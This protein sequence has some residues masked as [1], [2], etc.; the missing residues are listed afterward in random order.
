MQDG[1]EYLAGTAKPVIARIS[2]AT[3]AEVGVA[4]GDTISIS[5]D[6]GAMVLP[7]E[8]DAMPDRV[9]WV[10][11]NARG[12]AVR[13]TL[14]AGAGATVRLTRPDAPPVVGETEGTA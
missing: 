10:P 12:F 9:V 5:T 2:P 1:D 11:T 6:A 7:V 14:G 8:V 3:A 4:A 13:T